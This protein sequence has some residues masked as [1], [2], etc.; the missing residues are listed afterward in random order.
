[1]VTPDSTKIVSGSRDK[2]IKVWDLNNGSIIFACKFDY[3]T[4]IVISKKRNILV[5]GD[6]NGGVYAMNIF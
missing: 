4:V 3:I 5:I 6:S 2:T 1:V